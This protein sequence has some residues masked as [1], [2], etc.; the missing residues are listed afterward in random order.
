M[1]TYVTPTPTRSL[2][3]YLE[4]ENITFQISITNF[5]S[6]FVTFEQIL[7][8]GICFLSRLSQ[9]Y[10]ETKRPWQDKVGEIRLLVPTVKF[11]RD[12]GRG[13]GRDQCEGK[14]GFSSC[15]STE[16]IISN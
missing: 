6:F 1:R 7:S 16:K 8:F 10:D 12:S 11:C 13:T 14:K 15:G 5:V 4:V 3:L 2:S 9:F